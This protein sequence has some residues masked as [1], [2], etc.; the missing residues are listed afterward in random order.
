MQIPLDE[1]IVKKRI[2]KEMGD[3]SSLAESMKRFGQMSPIVINSRNQLIAGGRRLEAARYL[4]WRT[5]NAVVVDISD[6]LS[7]LEY[8]VEE[9]LQRQNFT[10][11]E[12]TL[13]AK[14]INKLRNPGFFRRIWNG[15]LN[16]F[17]K[18][19]RIEN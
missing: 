4:G 15:I 13:A 16:F 19:F 12:I 14:R 18:L 2:R 1:I 10:A 17:K 11:E 5:I 8:E 9:N 3:I 7:K 6:S